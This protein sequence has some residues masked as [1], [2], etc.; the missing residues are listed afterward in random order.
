MTATV[1]Q[2][3]NEVFTL[4]RT[5]WLADAS[6]LGVELRYEDVGPTDPPKIPTGGDAPSWVRIQLRHADGDQSSLGGETGT[7][8]FE[9]F[10]IITVQVFTPTGDGLVLNDTLSLIARNA[11]EGKTTSPGA[12]RLRRARIVAVGEDGPWYQSNVLVDFEYDEVK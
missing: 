5:A 11:F 12:V 4:F 1:T 2:A 6:S 3:R 10:G 9:R 7:R 8:I